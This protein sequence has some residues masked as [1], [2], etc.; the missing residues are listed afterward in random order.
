MQIKLTRFEI[1]ILEHHLEVP[2]AIAEALDQPVEIVET[3]TDPLLSGLSKYH[4]DTSYAESVNPAITRD[5]LADCV[6]GSTYWATFEDDETKQ[7]AIA[8]AGERLAEK[9]GQYAGR[10]LTFPTW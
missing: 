7:R 5:V 8:K 3:I 6:K 10:N 2:D 1:A 4:L 9:I